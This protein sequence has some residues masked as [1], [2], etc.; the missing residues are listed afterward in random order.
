MR[1]LEQFLWDNFIAVL[2]WPRID[3][4]LIVIYFPAFYQQEKSL[5]LL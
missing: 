2:G 4:I 5:K 3:L 1:E